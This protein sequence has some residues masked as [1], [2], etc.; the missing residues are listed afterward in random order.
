M[1]KMVPVNVCVYIYIYIYIY[2]Y[3]NVGDVFISVRT[4]TT[5]Q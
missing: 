2:K 4:S 1:N 3:L 5:L